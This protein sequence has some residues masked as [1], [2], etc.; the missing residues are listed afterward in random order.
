MTIAALGGCEL[1]DSDLDGVA[2]AFEIQKGWDPDNADQDE[3]GITDG[4]QD[5]DGDGLTDWLE[6][7]LGTD[8][9]DPTDPDGNDPD[10][11]DLPTWIEALV[12]TNPNDAD[13]DNGGDT[14]GYEI[15]AGTNPRNT[16][17]DT[18]LTR[19]DDH[20]ER[21]DTLKDRPHCYLL[22]YCFRIIFICTTAAACLINV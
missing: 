19:D 14:D 8:A 21:D 3:D 1:V 9:T 15:N 4:V 16:W 12:D 10:G 6:L 18:Q 20:D 22:C 17:D 13:S 7:G 2:D 5:S 11:D